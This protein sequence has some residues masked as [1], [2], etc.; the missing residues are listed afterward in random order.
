MRTLSLVT[1]AMALTALVTL[2]LMRV[3]REECGACP[4][5][6]EVDAEL[7]RTT[8]MAERIDHERRTCI[9]DRLGMQSLLANIDQEARADERVRIAR[10]QQ[11]RRAPGRAV[12][13]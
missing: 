13:P 12:K 1:I 5:V 6:A 11:K 2:T 4:S 7:D 3:S 8:A 9:E 10:E